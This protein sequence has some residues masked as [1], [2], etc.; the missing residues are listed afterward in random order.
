MHRT[1]LRL[2]L[3]SFL[4][5]GLWAQ[6]DVVTVKSPDGRIEFRLLDG[7]PPTPDTQLPHLAYQVDYD[8][9]P[10]IGT[11]YLG[12]EIYNQVPL[13]T[14]LG[15]VKTY[16]DAVDETYT[17]AAGKSKT[18]RNHFNEVVAEYLQNG[19]L[20][21]LISVEV[22][23]FNDGVAF[24]YVV[25]PSPPL[26][27]MRLENEI[28]QFN[29][30]RDGESYPLLFQTDAA[31][32]AGQY[33]RR[34]LSTIPYG[35]R[36]G[37]PLLLEQP[38]VGW[39]AIAEADLDE[40]A[41]L[42]LLRTDRT[43]LRARLTFRPDGSTLS[44]FAKTPLVTPWRVLMIADRP[45][46]L[47]ESNILANLNLPSKIKDTSW[48]QPGKAASSSWSGTGSMTTLSLQRTIDFAASAG[49]EYALIDGAWAAA[50]D[51]GAQDLLRAVPEIDMPV[52]LRLAAQK[53]VGV[54]LAVD[55]RALEAQMDEALENFEKWGVRGLRVEGLNRDDQDTVAAVHKLVAKAAEHRLMLAFGSGY[56]PDG[57]ERV[58]PNVLT[59][60]AALASDY[61]KTGAAANPQHEVTLAFTRLLAGPLDYG[62]GGFNN[63]TPASFEPRERRPMVL[64]TRAHQLALFVIFDSPLQRVVDDPDNY[65]G[66]KEFDFI[67]SVP[68]A[69]DSTRAMVGQVGEFIAIARSRGPEWYLGAIANDTAR[70][71]D[72]PLSFLGAGNYVAEL[73][74]DAPDAASDPKHTNIEQ[75]RVTASESLHLK[76]ASGGGAAVR[77]RPVN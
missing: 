38:G 19:S 2:A 48:I 71:I 26:L 1:V 12:F 23:A 27:E 28:T 10:L 34:T 49:L 14:K 35:S 56:K 58:Y 51:R 41:G 3:V 60:E 65:A 21:R 30:A 7:P 11:S 31:N 46:K 18:V 47:V 61:V 67:K 4:A 54:W 50:G 45:E 16:P 36:I 20:G 17:L 32:Y 53:K 24:R 5:T 13:G 9:K 43:K 77:F 69:W 22:R 75:R 64:G 59:T 63:A 15:L 76:L 39:V 62:L 29:F 74:T 55:W 33:N 68:A 66:V 6:Q 25:P 37:L 57:I 42:S 40:Y 8:G 70:E 44:V 73:Y 52:L 72:V